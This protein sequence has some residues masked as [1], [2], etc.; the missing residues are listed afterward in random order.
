M[1]TTRRR[2][3]PAGRLEHPDRPEYVRGGIVRRL[4]HR[5]AHV[6]LR[7]QM[8]DDLGPRRI[9]DLR[10]C[11][12]IPH[13]GYVQTGA[14]LNRALEVRPLSGRKVVDHGHAVAAGDQRVD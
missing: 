6:D 9:E 7:G 14:A 3:D 1:L 12:G 8:E 13:I 5:V 2:A 10:H 11:P 4:L